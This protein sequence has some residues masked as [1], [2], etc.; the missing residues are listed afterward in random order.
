MGSAIPSD[1]LVSI[2]LLGVTIHTYM[3]CQQEQFQHRIIQHLPSLSA[4]AAVSVETQ[5]PAADGEAGKTTKMAAEALTEAMIK[6]EEK[7]HE[8]T[9]E[10]E[11]QELKQQTKVRNLLL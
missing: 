3:L 11:E 6:E 10:L 9:V 1:S 2:T 4:D 5:S 8:Q 7:L